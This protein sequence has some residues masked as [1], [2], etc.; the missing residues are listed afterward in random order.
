[1]PQPNAYEAPG[2]AAPG[3]RRIP[4]NEIDGGRPACMTAR[5]DASVKQ[6]FQLVEERKNLRGV[7]SPAKNV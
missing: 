6:K 2:I 1:M 3:T 7:M 5:G 4:S